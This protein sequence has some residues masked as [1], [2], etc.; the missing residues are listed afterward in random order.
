M[1]TRVALRLPL[2]DNCTTSVVQ[3]WRLSC[4]DYPQAKAPAL[5][6]V[7]GHSFDLMSFLAGTPL[8]HILCAA[9]EA[10]WVGFLS[11]EE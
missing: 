4:L 1:G 9:Y 2:G 6:R 11:L 3:E 7:L 10:D 8:R 5:Q